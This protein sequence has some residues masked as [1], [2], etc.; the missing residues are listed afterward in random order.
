MAVSEL[1]GT[2]E[3]GLEDDPEVSVEEARQLSAS[4]RQFKANTPRLPPVALSARDSETNTA[5]ARYG[6]I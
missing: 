5:V 6:R 1:N 2:V 4:L 3:S